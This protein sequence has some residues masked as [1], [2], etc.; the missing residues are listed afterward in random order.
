MNRLAR[1]LAP[2]C[3]PLALVACD[4]G[5]VTTLDLSG[6]LPDDARLVAIGDSIFDWNVEGGRSAPDVAGAA[7]GVSMD[8]LAVGGAE[9]LGGFAP[10]PEQYEDDDWAWLVMAGG[11]N[12]LNDRCACGQCDDVMDA[13]IEPDGLGGAIPEF[14]GAV[15]DSGVQVLVMGY[16]EVPDDAE[17]GFD[18]CDDELEVLRERE[19]RMGESIE[20][21][22]FLDM[23]LH[24]KAHQTDRYDDDRVH[25]SVEG[26]RIMGEEIARAIAEAAR[27]E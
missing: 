15:A 22:H 2:L 4:A 13:L 3:L 24:I 5:P 18:R 21:V 14:A 7:L 1:R 17:F 27:G 26:S 8:N 6:A 16:H 9:V 12:D 23:T 25:P 10:I 20:G 19:R 11:G